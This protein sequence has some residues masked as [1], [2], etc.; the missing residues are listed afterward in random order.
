MQAVNKKFI[1]TTVF[2][3]Q[4]N[5]IVVIKNIIITDAVTDMAFLM[6]ILCL[7]IGGR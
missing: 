6:R 5:G 2:E 3:T 7:C 1:T 4:I